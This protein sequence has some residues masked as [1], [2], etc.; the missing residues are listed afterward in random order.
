MNTVHNVSSV[1]I[2]Q[3][4]LVVQID[5]TKREFL[6]S[7]ISSALAG[8]TAEERNTLEVSASGYGIHWPLLDEDLSIDGLLGI[9]HRP[10][11]AQKR[12]PAAASS[13]RQS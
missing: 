8:A 6:L 9:E 12:R 11:T 5:G 3:D 13:A 2:V 4:K 7:D 1:K 10:V